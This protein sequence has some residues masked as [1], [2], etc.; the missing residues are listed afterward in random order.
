MA[1][2]PGNG[3]EQL[4]TPG[5]FRARQYRNRMSRSVW[6]AWSLLPLWSA[7]G[8]PKAPASWP[9]STRFARFISRA[10]EPVRTPIESAVPF[11]PAIGA[12]FAVT[13]L[14]WVAADAGRRVG[15]ILPGKW[16]AGEPQEQQRPE[17]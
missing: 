4:A 2:G 14:G 12:W 7:L 15:G 1:H 5:Y 16:D 8:G 10:A 13:T 17:R 9:H 3:S 11:R 6:S